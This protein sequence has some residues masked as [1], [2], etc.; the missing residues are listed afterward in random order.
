MTL[1]SHVQ[2]SLAVAVNT[3]SQGTVRLVVVIVM[4]VIAIMIMCAFLLLIRRNF[5]ASASDVTSAQLSLHDIREMH[6]SGKI[7]DEEFEA[8][9][10][11]ILPKER[12]THPEAD[13]LKRGKPGDPEQGS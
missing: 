10:Q 2:A 7:T 12:I 11:L 1:T 6:N 9:K 5:L 3:Q 8:M 4:M 13:A